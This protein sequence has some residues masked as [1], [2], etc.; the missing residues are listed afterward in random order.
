MPADRFPFGA[1]RMAAILFCAPR[2]VISSLGF[3]LAPANARQSAQILR[4]G[5]PWICR[6][7]VA[8]MQ[9]TARYKVE[10]SVL[11]ETVQAEMIGWRRGSSWSH[12][13]RRRRSP[14][15]CATPS[16]AAS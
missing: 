11:D 12:R 6:Q 9:V 2:A 1:C 15:S 4:C 8:R 7:T 13:S 14:G 10:G 5:Q 16:G 3:P